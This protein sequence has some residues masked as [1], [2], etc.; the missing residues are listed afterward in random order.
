MEAAFKLVVAIDT[1]CGRWAYSYVGRHRAGYF[2]F[3]LALNSAIPLVS[4]TA[5]TRVST[6]H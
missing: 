3:T 5:W 6:L 1:T 4:R 2:V